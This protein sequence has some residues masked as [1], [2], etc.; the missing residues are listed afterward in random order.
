MEETEF[1]RDYDYVTVNDDL[2]TCLE[3]L[4]KMV[5]MYRQSMHNRARFSMELKNGLKELTKKED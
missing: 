1:I 5:C 3:E 2:E 4:Y